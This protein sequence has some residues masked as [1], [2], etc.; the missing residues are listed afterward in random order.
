MANSA[1]FADDL[2]RSFPRELSH[3][4]MANAAD[5]KAGRTQNVAALQPDAEVGHHVRL[6]L[7]TPIAA[8]NA[9][10]PMCGAA[11]I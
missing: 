7:T 1:P 2:I 3:S 6:H 4:E 11:T 8:S 9:C 10:Q 5:W